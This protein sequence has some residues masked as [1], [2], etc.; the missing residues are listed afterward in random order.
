[1]TL[2]TIW[3]WESDKTTEDKINNTVMLSSDLLFLPL[4]QVIYWSWN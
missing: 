4:K 2:I 3:K 1:M